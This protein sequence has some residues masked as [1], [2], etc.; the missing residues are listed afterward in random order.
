MGLFDRISTPDGMLELARFLEE[1]SARVERLERSAAD[2]VALYDAE[3]DRQLRWW[4]T[5]NA[6]VSGVCANERSTIS[7]EMVREH[8]VQFADA[9][10]GPIEIVVPAGTITPEMEE[11]LARGMPIKELKT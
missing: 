7:D 3:A 1:L 5:F 9:A 4:C 2:A 10:H 6:Y 8:A 11:Q